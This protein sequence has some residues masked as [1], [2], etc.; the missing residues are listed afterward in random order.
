[1]S[2]VV[3]GLGNRTRSDDGVGPCV[4]DA[5]RQDDAVASLATL[6]EVGDDTTVMVEALAGQRLAI[7]V[8]AVS[9]GGRPGTVRRIEGADLHLVPFPRASTHTLPLDEALG[10]AAALGHQPRV[11]I[12]GVEIERC[13]PGF[14]LSPA[15]AASVPAACECVCGVIDEEHAHA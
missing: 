2:V 15:V 14:T 9:T 1:M 12:V 11:V 3:I 8:D 6:V 10:L 5:L 7:I 4:L 13:D